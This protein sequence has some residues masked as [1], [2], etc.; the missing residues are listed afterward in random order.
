[1]KLRSQHD[2]DTDSEGSEC[3]DEES[4]RLHWGI[5]TIWWK[6]CSAGAKTVDV[7]KEISRFSSDNKAV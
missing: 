2:Y 6:V 5:E 3:E 4:I 7:T 1:M